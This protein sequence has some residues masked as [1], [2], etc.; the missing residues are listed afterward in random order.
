M[1]LCCTGIARCRRHHHHPHHEYLCHHHHCHH[2]HHQQPLHHVP[3]HHHHYH[4]QGDARGLVLQG[5]YYSTL[6]CIQTYGL[7]VTRVLWQFRPM[8]LLSQ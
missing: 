3:H 7:R 8:R 4:H 1:Q 5:L 6:H 2:H